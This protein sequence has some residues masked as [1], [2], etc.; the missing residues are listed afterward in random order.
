ML[1]V[2]SPSVLAREE[3]IEEEQ[4]G[5]QHGLQARWAHPEATAAVWVAG[6][7]PGGLAIPQFPFS[8]PLLLLSRLQHG[9]LRRVQPHN[10]RIAESLPA[11]PSR[12]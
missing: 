10:I 8:I 9:Q 1:A 11:K 2:C 3:D 5:A 4:V 7:P 12:L 6:V